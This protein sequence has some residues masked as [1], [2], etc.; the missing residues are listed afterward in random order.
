MRIA[1]VTFHNAFNYGATLQCAA[2]SK[3]LSKQGVDVSVID[4]LPGYVED[5]KSVF[6]YLKDVKKANNKI[7]AAAKGVAYLRFAIDIHKRNRAFDDFVRKNMNLTRTYSTERELEIDPPTADAYICGSDQVWNKVITNNAFDDVF[8]LQFVK[9]GLRIAYAVSLGETG[10]SENKDELSSLTKK[11][12]FISVREENI[13]VELGKVLSRDV[14]T[15]VDPTLLLDEADYTAFE[16]PVS[17]APDRY[18]LVYNIQNSDLSI[19]LAEKIAREKGLQIIDISPNPFQKAKGSIK[20]I[21]VG[22]G[23]FLTLIKNAEYIVTNSFH[24]TV[25][26]LIYRKQFYTIPHKKRPGRMVSLLRLCGLE[27]RIINSPDAK[28][29]FNEIDYENVSKKIRRVSKDSK[30]LLLEAIES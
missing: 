22:P 8:F 9:N 4:Y 3:M 18:L 27:D 15:V 14:A 25:F 16:K 13:A 20:K 26:S 2:L 1:I 28:L 30:Q 11:F 12:D 7:K 5:K 6:R 21:S 24:G 17:F 23:E 10:P 29:S 19:S